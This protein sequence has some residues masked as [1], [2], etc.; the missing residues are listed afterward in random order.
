[1][2]SSTSQCWKHTFSYI[3]EYMEDKYEGFIIIESA[4]GD[5]R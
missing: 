4:K 3:L 5:E 1:M 2:Q